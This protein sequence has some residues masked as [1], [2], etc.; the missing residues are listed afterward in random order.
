MTFEEFIRN[1]HRNYGSEAE[2]MKREKIFEANL[3][4]YAI[5]RDQGYEVNVTDLS[6]KTPSEIEK[7]ASSYQPFDDILNQQTSKRAKGILR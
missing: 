7:M 6:D 3:E 4:K 2:K 5:L 1:F